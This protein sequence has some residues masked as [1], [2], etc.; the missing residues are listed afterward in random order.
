MFSQ[1]IPLG[2]QVVVF[3]ATNRSLGTVL[4]QTGDIYKI[5]LDTGAEALYTRSEI[6]RYYKG[7]GATTI[8]KGARTI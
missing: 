6:E 8:K 3:T 1:P 4:N 5:K 2:Q 7:K